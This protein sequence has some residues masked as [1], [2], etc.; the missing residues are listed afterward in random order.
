VFVA[1]ISI[2]LIGWFW[3]KQR[4]RE[5]AMEEQAEE[6]QTPPARPLKEMREV[7]A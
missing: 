3:P 4:D 2:T 1:P 6:G 5:R 7:R